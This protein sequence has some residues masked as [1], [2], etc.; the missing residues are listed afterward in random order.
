MSQTWRLRSNLRT[1]APRA[2][3]DDA[4]F[5]TPSPHFECGRG[6]AVGDLLFIAMLVWAGRLLSKPVR[7]ARFW[8]AVTESAKVTALALPTL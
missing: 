6:P 5:R 1:G 4:A 8:S 7:A 3:A 2:A